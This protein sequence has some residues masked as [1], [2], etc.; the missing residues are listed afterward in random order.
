MRISDYGIME[1]AGMEFHARHGCLERERKEGNRFVVDV[2]AAYLLKKPAKT[3]R[4]EDAADYSLIYRLVRDEMDR[5]SDL[6][7]NVAQRICDAIHSRFRKELPLIKVTV[8]KQH[9]P[10]DGPCE[11]SRITV[12]SRNPVCAAIYFNLP[13]L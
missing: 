8:S 5:P 9:P 1:L 12:Y 13:V 2:K 6:L 11:W 10:V 4:L 7:E 3:D